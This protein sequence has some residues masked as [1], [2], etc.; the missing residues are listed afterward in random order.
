MKLFYNLVTLVTERITGLDP[1]CLTPETIDIWIPSWYGV[2]EFLSIYS[3]FGIVIVA[4]IV[5]A[6]VTIKVIDHELK[7]EKKEES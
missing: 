6:L 1:E 5:T 3:A 4:I 2:K 7:K